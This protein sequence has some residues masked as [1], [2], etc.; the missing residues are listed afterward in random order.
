M[1]NV[2]LFSIDATGLLKQQLA[3]FGIP[4]IRDLKQANDESVTA[5]NGSST[6]TLSISVFVGAAMFMA[7]AL[8]A[9][10]NVQRVRKRQMERDGEAEPERTDG[11]ERPRLAIDPV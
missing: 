10:Y 2:L 7:V 5:S 4:G 6:A 9:L 1:V 11:C 3:D 8:G